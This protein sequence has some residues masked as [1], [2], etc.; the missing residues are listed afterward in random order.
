[1]VCDTE[2]ICASS[3]YRLLCLLLGKPM[4]QDG[5]VMKATKLSDQYQWLTI[6]QVF[7]RVEHIMRGLS[8]LGLKP[9]QKMI[10]FSETRL[11]WFITALS[12]MELDAVIVTLFS[13]LGEIVIF[14]FK[15]NFAFSLGKDGLIHGM[16]QTEAKFVMT[17]F[18]LLERIAAFIDQT[19]NIE[20][21]VYIRH[22]YQ[23]Q[24]PIPKFPD[25]IQLIALD[26]LESIGSQQPKVDIPPPN[27]DSVSLIMYTSGT[28]GIPKAVILHH[29][30]VRSALVALASNVTDL[31][32]E[33]P[34]HVY[35]SFLPMAHIMGLMFE[36]FLFTGGVR[37]GYSSPHTLTDSSPAHIAGQ[38][39]DLNLL[40]PTVLI[41]VPLI[42]DR[43]IKEI[44]SKL[45]SRSPILPPLFT[46]L[47]DY[48]IRWTKRG[49]GTPLINRL[50]CK[51][52][53]E[54]FGGRLK[55]I[56]SGGAPLNPR[57]EELIRAALD[58]HLMQGVFM[59]FICLVFTFYL[60]DMVVRKRQAE[61]LECH[62][63]RLI[64]EKL[65]ILWMVFD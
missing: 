23:K 62:K 54:Q 56:I 5:K 26:E 10:I 6:G 19:P 16:K 12:L 57:T 52:V 14:L 29:R 38:R 37:I 60:Q 20:K 9:R 44:Y 42:L 13:N 18:D 7:E 35:A 30:Q 31:I 48:K 27:P 15:I 58:I 25:H 34:K 45:S 22:E 64:L 24:K 2:L 65:V 17:T 8:W 50:V 46:Y 47:M 4:T 21:I 59:Q 41:C 63:Y 49:Y 32:E 53:Q 28:T 43:I 40:Q 33:G 11:E 55:F 1:M 36:L 61:L 39:G 51:R 3:I